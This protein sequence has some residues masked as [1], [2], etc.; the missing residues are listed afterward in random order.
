MRNIFNL[1][2]LLLIILATMLSAQ[3]DTLITTNGETLTG[4][5]KKMEQGVLTIKTAYSDS[6]F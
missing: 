3:T 6:D 4:E 1:I 2:M 5:I